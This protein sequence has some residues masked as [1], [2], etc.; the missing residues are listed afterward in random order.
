MRSGS[1]ASDAAGCLVPIAFEVMNHLTGEQ[2]HIRLGGREIDKR[3]SIDERRAGNAHVDFLGAQVI[4]ATY[5]ITQL[6]AAHDAVV[7]EEA[8]LAIE[9]IAVGNQLHLGHQIAG[10]LV[11]RHEGTGPRRCVFRH[12][13]AV[14][15]MQSLGITGGHTHSAVGDATDAVHLR[16]ILFA[17]KHTAGVTHF[18][19]ITSFV[20]AG[21]ESVVHPEEGAN[22]HFLIRLAQLLHPVGREQHNFA[23][24]DVMLHL[25]SQVGKCRGLG[26]RSPGTFLAPDDDRGAPQAIARYNDSFFGE[27]EH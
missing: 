18:F 21:R 22:L 14:G 12:C 27:D 15:D 1:F 17:H 11:A 13:A 4:E 7:A 2:F 25:K 23:G 8:A 5:I 3:T 24:S 6:R 26:G 16:V 19:Y 9:R 10:E 20:A